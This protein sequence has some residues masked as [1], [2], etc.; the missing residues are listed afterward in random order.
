MEISEI[1]SNPLVWGLLVWLI[2]R[3]F[4]SS[5][6]GTEETPKQ[7][8]VKPDNR[9]NPVPNQRSTSREK[10]KSVMT[11]IEQ[12]SQK[13]KP[14]LQTV[15]EAYESMKVETKGQNEVFNRG[16]E[17][18]KKARVVQQ[19]KQKPKVNRNIRANN[20]KVDK[21][22]VMQGVIWSE[23]LGSPRSKNPHYTRKKRH[24]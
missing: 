20:L 5:K 1:L 11:T 9:S 2:S 18:T 15:Q 21:Q 3:I 13:A 6:N 4:S 17:R 14:S 12:T 23:I 22:K 8:P 7:Q 19:P 10:P 16:N 24:S